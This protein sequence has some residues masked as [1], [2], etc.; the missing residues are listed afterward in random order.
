MACFPP[1]NKAVFGRAGGVRAELG[2]LDSVTALNDECIGSGAKAMDLDASSN[3][4][5]RLKMREYMM[6]Y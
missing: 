1:I 2:P 4:V 6:E 3:R 5:R